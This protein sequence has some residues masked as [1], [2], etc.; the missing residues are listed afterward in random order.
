MKRA[1]WWR[2]VIVHTKRLEFCRPMV[3]LWSVHTVEKVDKNPM[4]GLVC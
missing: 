2:R 3:K 4:S 1:V